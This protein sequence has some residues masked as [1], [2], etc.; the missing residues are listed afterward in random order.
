MNSDA[1]FTVSHTNTQSS[2]L[3][4]SGVRYSDGGEYMCT[5][6]YALCPDEVDCSAATP[7]T[8]SIQL[9]LPGTHVCMCVLSG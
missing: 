9:N 8:G 5:V 4:I 3:Q 6:E 7:V 2:T 1:R